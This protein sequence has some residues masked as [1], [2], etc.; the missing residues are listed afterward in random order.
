MW[1]KPFV[2]FLGLLLSTIVGSAQ[3]AQDSESV[4]VVGFV[5]GQPINTALVGNAGAAGLTRL[6]DVFRSYGATVRTVDPTEPVPTD[7]ELLVIIQPRR[8]LSVP[9]T[10]YIWD[11]LQRGGHLLLGIDPNGHNGIN[12]ERGNSGL[13]QLLAQEFGLS[14]ADDF[15][16][17]SWFSSQSLQDVVTSWSEAHPEDYVAHPIVQPLIDFSLPVRFWGARSVLVEGIPSSASTFPLIYAERP[18]GETGRINLRNDSQEQFALNIG[19]D[20][21]GRLPLAAGSEHH[22][23]GS[24]VGVVG[25]SELFLNIFGLTRIVGRETLPRY[26][27]NDLLVQRLVAWLMG[28]PE[29]DWPTLSD[30]FTAIAVDGDLS[31]WPSDLLS[32]GSAPTALE[33]GGNGIS[34]ISSFYDDQFLYLA[35]ETLKPEDNDTVQLE[36]RFRDNASID[37]L[38]LENGRLFSTNGTAESSILDASYATGEIVEVRVPLRITG[39]PPQIEQICIGGANFVFSACTIATIVTN[40]VQTIN[41]SPTAGSTGPNAFTANSANLRIGPGEQFPVIELLPARTL[42]RA[43]GRTEDSNWIQVEN[44]RYSGWISLPLIVANIDI[45][46]LPVVE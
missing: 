3:N 26:A 10:A 7:I 41:T 12:T 25:D 13:N 1:R 30:D 2:L 16:I 22:D 24:R 46:K 20:N 38:R 6:A 37:A 31:D 34:N 43:I 14:I 35:V 44:G 42:F 11:F 40:T 27:G 5:Q 29:D 19:Q 18:H 8:P 4:R 15:L 9:T 23:T 17:E 21:Q 33:P 32:T 39:F 28:I 45:A 36:L